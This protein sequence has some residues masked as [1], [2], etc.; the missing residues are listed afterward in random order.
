MEINKMMLIWSIFSYILPVLRQVRNHRYYLVVLGSTRAP[1]VTKFLV[2][3]RTPMSPVLYSV[4][5][6]QPLNR[7]L[8]VVPPIYSELRAYVLPTLT[9]TLPAKS[10]NSV[11][12]LRIVASCVCQLTPDCYILCVAGWCLAKS[13]VKLQWWEGLLFSEEFDGFVV[14]RLAFVCPVDDFGWYFEAVLVGELLEFLL[15]LISILGWIGPH[16]I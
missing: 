16:I 15:D 10:G 6:H 1:K 2:E 8:R 14:D 12:R 5:Y 9:V 4:V 3:H 11:N 7:V 13:L